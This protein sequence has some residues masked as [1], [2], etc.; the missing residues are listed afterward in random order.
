VR[1]E[2]IEMIKILMVILS[3]V[4]LWSTGVSA[5][6]DKYEAACANECNYLTRDCT[7]YIDCRVAKTQCLESCMQRKVWENLAVTLEKLTTVLEKQA[8][9]KEDERENLRANSSV[10]LSSSL[11][12]PSTFQKP[13]EKKSDSMQSGK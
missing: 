4:L 8:Q 1:K 3:A 6:G 10:P 13:V 5:E 7:A 2:E 11:P 12:Q 9:E